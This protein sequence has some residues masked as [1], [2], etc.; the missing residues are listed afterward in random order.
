[1]VF[2]RIFFFMFILC[3]MMTQFTPQS[4][5][6]SWW[7]FLFPA[8]PTGP[9]PSQTLRAPFA[10]E[11]AVLED[12]DAAGTQNNAT[13]L[14]QRHR[15]DESITKWVNEILPQLMSYKA[16]TYEAEFKNNVT[17]FSKIGRSEYIDA[18]K[19]NSFFS[20]LKTQ[21]YDITSFVSDYPVIL[22]QGAVENRYL[23]VYRVPVMVTFIKTGTTDYDDITDKD[24]ISRQ[25]SVTFQIGRT[26]DAMNDHGILIE[27]WDMKPIK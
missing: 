24:S 1:M 13:P 2:Y 26:R 16:P 3:A 23:W 17:Y 27:T 9:D 20:T 15:N 5:A 19:S 25:F 22:N 10:D 18:L 11:D 8:P 7:D 14:H 12:L 6:E 21:R 4:R